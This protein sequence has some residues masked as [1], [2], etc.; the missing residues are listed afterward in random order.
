MTLLQPASILHIQ[1]A[2]GCGKSTLL[3]MIA[4]LRPHCGKLFWQNNGQNKVRPESD[5]FYLGHQ[6][7]IKRHLTVSE[8]ID[9]LQHL[10]PGSS[11]NK[12]ECLRTLGLIKFHDTLAGQLSQGQRQRLTL[13]PLLWITYPLWILDEPLV[14]LDKSARSWLMQQLN[15]HLQKKGYIIL[16]SHEALCEINYPILSLHLGE[17]YA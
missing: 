4:G 9:Y 12:K 15:L 7:A 17:T 14:A 2:N 8:N 16:A 3:A 11:L 5:L 1:G 10:H 13:A 6:Q